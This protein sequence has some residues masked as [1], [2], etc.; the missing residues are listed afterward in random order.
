MITLE[1]I[2]GSLDENKNLTD[3][4]RDNIFGL[5]NVLK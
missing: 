5:V 1:S 4:V 3:E 2:K